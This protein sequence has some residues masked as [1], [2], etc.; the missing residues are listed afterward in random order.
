M[1]AKGLRLPLPIKLW[2]PS[3]P[4]VTRLRNGKI[5]VI[6][7]RFRSLVCT[8]DYSGEIYPSQ[9][10]D[11]IENQSTD[12]FVSLTAIKASAAFSVPFMCKIQVMGLTLLEL[13]LGLNTVYLPTR[14][15]REIHSQNR[16]QCNIF[17]V[18]LFKETHPTMTV[19]NN[20]PPVSP[21]E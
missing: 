7:S 3:E 11:S 18:H 1:T 9:I 2:R 6:F 14:L 21:G 15:R 8:S 10:S 4:K 16:F 17:T 5:S 19:L 13:F 20:Q 12:G